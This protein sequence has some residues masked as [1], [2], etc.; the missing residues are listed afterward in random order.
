VSGGR[1]AWRSDAPYVEC[2]LGRE[3]FPAPEKSPIVY[4]RARDGML[5]AL[6]PSD[7]HLLLGASF[8]RSAKVAA[9]PN[10]KLNDSGE[11]V[12]TQIINIDDELV[13]HAN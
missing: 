10:L 3:K 12:S 11:Y 13:V 9:T 4:S 5:Q 1:C 6:D 7:S 2:A 8:C